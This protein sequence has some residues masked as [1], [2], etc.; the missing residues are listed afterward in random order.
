MFTRIPDTM[1]VAMIVRD[2]I[3]VTKR[4]IQYI[5]MKV[6]NKALRQYREF[7]HYLFCKHHGIA[8]ESILKWLNKGNEF[9]KPITDFEI[10]KAD[11]VRFLEDA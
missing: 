4:K 7:G 2:T 5:D 6:F 11:E 10:Y 1:V 3:Y 9:I 8:K